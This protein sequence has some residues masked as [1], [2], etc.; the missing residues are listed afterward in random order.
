MITKTKVIYERTEKK[1]RGTSPPTKK[2]AAVA[3]LTKTL[4]IFKILKS[5]HLPNTVTLLKL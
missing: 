2:A 4:F 3:V 1:E 5:N